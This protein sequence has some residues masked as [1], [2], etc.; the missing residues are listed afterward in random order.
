MRNYGNIATA[1]WQDSDFLALSMNAQRTYLLLI[2]QNNISSVGSLA[3]TMRRWSRMAA[4]SSEDALLDGLAEL[5]ASRFI[6]IDWDHEEILIRTFVK[7][8]GGHTNPKRLLSIASAA[9]AVASVHLG[10]ILATELDALGVDHGLLFP[11]V[12]SHPDADGSPIESPRVVVAYAVGTTTHNPQQHSSLPG[13]PAE[14]QR[15]DVN[16][17]CETLQA[18]M[19][20]NGIKEPTITKEWRRE[21]RL[22]LDKDGYP[23]DIVMHVLEWSQK[24][25]FWKANIQSVPK[26][27]QKFGQLLLKSQQD[28]SLAA[29]TGGRP[30]WE[31]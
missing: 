13:L 11:E 19:V 26:L 17:I 29:N 23:L 12:D 14:E 6:A 27:R 18:R 1:I 7:W 8:D 24:D 16:K 3:I 9:R 10:R 22:L 20:G 5:E 21:A 2:T 25:R 30:S 28:T 15:D 4:D 31:Q